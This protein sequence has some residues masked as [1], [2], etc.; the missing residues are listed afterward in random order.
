MRP[1]DAAGRAA[2]D[3]ENR[4]A[5]DAWLAAA[6]LVRPPAQHQ[7]VALDIDA[8]VLAWFRAQ[9]EGYQARINTVLRAFYECHRDAA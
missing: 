3:P 9:G 8:D 6:P 7:P 4:D 5:S 2:A 1:P